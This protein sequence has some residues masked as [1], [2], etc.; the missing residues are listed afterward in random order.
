M[1]SAN[2]YWLQD[3]VK[4]FPLQQRLCPQDSKKCSVDGCLLFLS[5]Q[6]YTS[7]NNTLYLELGALFPMDHSINSPCSFITMSSRQVIR[8]KVARSYL[9]T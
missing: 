5:N 3:I 2:C 1:S 7:L 8:I 9:F 4:V 6:V